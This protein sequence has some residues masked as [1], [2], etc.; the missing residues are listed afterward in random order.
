MGGVSFGGAGGAPFQRQFSV[1]THIR[2][3]LVTFNIDLKCISWTDRSKSRRTRIISRSL[4]KSLGSLDYKPRREMTS[5]YSFLATHD[6]GGDRDSHSERVVR[7]SSMRIS[8]ADSCGTLSLCG[9]NFAIVRYFL[10]IFANW[11]ERTLLRRNS[12]QSFQIGYSLPVA[13]G[14]A[15]SAHIRYRDFSGNP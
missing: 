10:Y 9:K 6:F 12:L 1:Q 7:K 13:L 8:S 3:E 5:W 11:K 15:S 2:N 4:G 14:R